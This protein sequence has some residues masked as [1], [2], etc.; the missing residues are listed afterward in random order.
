[1]PRVIL[2]LLLLCQSFCRSTAEVPFA[3]PGLLGSS[4]AR[5]PRVFYVRD[6]AATQALFPRPEV[7][8]AMVAKAV[9][10]VTGKSSPAEAWRS[11]VKPEDVVGVKVHT[12]P[13]AASGTRPAVA[14]AI[15]RGLLE[16]GH[17]ASRIILWDRRLGDLR[18]AGFE[19]LARELGVRV[20]GAADAG[21]DAAVAY[22]NPFLGQLVFGDLEFERTPGAA[23]TN[24]VAGR[25]SHFSRLLTQ[26]ITRHILVAPL[27]NHNHAGVSGILYTTASAVT[28]NF[29]RFEVNP[30]LLVSA[31]PEIFGHPI[32]ADRLALCVVDALIGQYEGSQRSLLHYAAA[33]NE[34]RFSTDPVAIDVVSLEELNRLR[35]RAGASSITNRMAL[36]ENARLLELGSDDLRKIELTP[37]E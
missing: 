22:E 18:A 16:A 3:D 13:G 23:E 32:I 30:S 4:E 14:A 21:F 35:I 15:V 2:T 33:L 31:V 26:E 28:D 34:L 19:T 20:A 17:P 5:P 24:M 8:S 7:V 11:L 25:R 10:A 9:V 12:V 37:V 6:P 36:F 27:L 1:M 29:I